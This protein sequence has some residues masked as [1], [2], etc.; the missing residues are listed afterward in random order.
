MANKTEKKHF[1]YF[2]YLTLI[3]DN[4]WLIGQME[5]ENLKIL[6]LEHFFL[7]NICFL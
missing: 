4:L 2:H 6:K 7:R 1:F 3:V 5:L